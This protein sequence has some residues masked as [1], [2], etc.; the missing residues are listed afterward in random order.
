MS[1]TLDAMESLSPV[2]GAEI[3]LF[4]GGSKCPDPVVLIPWA[5][6]FQLHNEKK[7]EEELERT[8]RTER[9]KTIPNSKQLK[10]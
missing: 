2:N 3:C 8:E 7:K 5:L 10:T 1:S 6:F 9:E 4:Y